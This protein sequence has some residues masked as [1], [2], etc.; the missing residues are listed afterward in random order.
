MRNF[1]KKNRNFSLIFIFFVF[2]SNVFAFFFRTVCNLV[3]FGDKKNKPILSTHD[4]PDNGMLIN[5][6]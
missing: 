6:Y 1:P 5:S 3:L 2:F 4:S